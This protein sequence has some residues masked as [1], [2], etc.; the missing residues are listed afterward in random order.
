MIFYIN[1]NNDMSKYLPDDSQ[2]KSGLA[3]INEEFGGT[4][5]MSGADVHIMFEGLRPNE[6]PGIRTLLSGYP[7]VNGVT[8]RYS[9]DST[10]TLFDLDVPKTENQKALGKQISNRFGGNCV[11]DPA[12]IGN[13]FRSRA[14]HGSVVCD[15]AV[16]VR[17][18]CHPIN[19]RICHRT[20]RRYEYAVG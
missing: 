8:Y 12:D 6:V 15:G 16:V 9:A 5:Q 10:H 20:E 2:M 7:N 11:V 4:S 13:D 3:V 17:T 19:C 1:V 18:R 14:D